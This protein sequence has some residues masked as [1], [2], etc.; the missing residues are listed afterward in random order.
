MELGFAY[1]TTS[2]AW[3]GYSSKHKGYETLIIWWWRYGSNEV[4][5]RQSSGVFNTL[6][7]DCTMV[8]SYRAY[9]G[10]VW[11]IKTLLRAHT[12]EELLL[13]HLVWFKGLTWGVCH[14]ETLTKEGMVLMDFVTWLFIWIV[15]NP[16]FILCFILDMLG[17]FAWSLSPITFC[18]GS[19]L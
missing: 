7:L 15:P 5:S 1:G 8:G 16:S 9:M 17:A 4:P 12:L 10:L 11:A 2:K 14:L 6:I 13:N 18:L 3:L 19:N